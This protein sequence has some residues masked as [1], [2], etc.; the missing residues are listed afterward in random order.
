MACT[1]RDL[2]ALAGELAEVRA[3]AG[4]GVVAVTAEAEQRGIIAASQFASTAA[5]VADAAWHSRREASSIAKVAALLQRAEYQPVAEAVCTADID[6]PSAVAC[7]Q[8]FAKLVPDLTD[9]AKPV[10]LGHLLDVA[11]VHGPVG[12]RQLRDEILIRYGD[13]GSF[14]E[15]CERRRRHIELSAGR[16]TVLGLWEYQLTIDGE[17]RAVLEAA[18]G[19]GSAPQVDGSVDTCDM[20][21]V[22]RRRGEALIDALSRAVAA[23]DRGLSPASPKAILMLTMDYRD[24]AKSAAAKRGWLGRRDVGAARS[25]DGAARFGDAPELPDDRPTAR[26]RGP[27]VVLGSRAAG[28][29]IG[30]ETV[31]RLACDAGIIPV[32]LGGEGEV[33]DQGRMERLFTR[34]QVRALWL[35]DRHCTFPGCDV[36]AAWCDSH[37]LVHWVDGGDTDL[38]N[39]ALLC[40]R[41]HTIVHRDELAGN[42]QAD[43][44]RAGGDPGAGSRAARAVRTIQ[45]PHVSWDLR[46]GS[47]RVAAPRAPDQRR[48]A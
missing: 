13:D 29:L 46:P 30:R 5:W 40:P 3:L 23:A 33:L 9:A 15:Q 7:G 37:H 20:R 1:D 14:E 41:H 24:L 18:I 43:G 2:V 42:V 19:P 12:V 32:V 35:R 17:G 39:A 22:G 28:E 27:A 36:P 21:P 48:I 16:Q 44:V 31:R 45:G 10:V 47:Y 34:G 25:G 6:L 11:A 38:S 8:E 4:A 26:A